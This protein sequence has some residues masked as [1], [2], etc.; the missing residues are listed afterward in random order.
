MKTSPPLKLKN[1]DRRSREFLS[2]DEI[3][4]L[5]A[6]ARKTGRHRHRDATMILIA[7]RHALRVSEL[8]ALRWTQID[9]DLGLIQVNRKKNGISCAHP[10]FGPEIRALRKLKREVL[11]SPY[12]F[13]TERNGP[14]TAS[15]FRKILARAGENAKLDIPVH[16]HMLRHSTGYKLANEGVDTRSIQQYLGHR[17]IQ[18]T[19]KY[20]EI[21]PDKFNE[22][23]HD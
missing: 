4:R 2:P 8:V 15:T 6:G 17:N 9:L 10:L 14:I 13:L 3:D 16:P 11:D 12:V 7:Y 1:T 21:S 5:I 19:T 18:H 22:F 20:T 23:W